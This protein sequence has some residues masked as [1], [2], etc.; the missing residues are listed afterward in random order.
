MNFT[1]TALKNLFSKPVTTQY[2]F[3][4]RKYPERTRGQISIDIDTCVFCGLCSK[5]CP[6]G[7][8]TVNRED[9]SWSIDRFGCIQCGYCIDSC[10]KKSLSMLPNYTPPGSRKTVDTIKKE[11]VSI[12]NR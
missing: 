6:S 3:Q 10:N 9:K 12:E 11:D 4:P 5:K 1:K 7:A 2:P 8:I